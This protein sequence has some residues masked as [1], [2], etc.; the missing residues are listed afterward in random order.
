MVSF[1]LTELRLYGMLP[2][3][4]IKIVLIG[5]VTKLEIIKVTCAHRDCRLNILAKLYLLYGRTGSTQD[6]I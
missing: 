6:G 1:G 3:L 2:I 4:N 5:S